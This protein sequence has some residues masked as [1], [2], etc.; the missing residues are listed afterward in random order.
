MKKNKKGRSIYIYIYKDIKMRVVEKKRR[1][2]LKIGRSM[3]R[4]VYFEFIFVLMCCCF[5]QR[6]CVAEDLL[7]VGTQ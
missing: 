1:V 4:F 5:R 2:Y 3:K 7:N 6:T